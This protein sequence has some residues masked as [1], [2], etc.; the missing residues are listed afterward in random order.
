MIVGKELPKDAETRL[1]LDLEN[2]QMFN[3]EPAPKPGAISVFCVQQGD[4]NHLPGMPNAPGVPEILTTQSMYIHGFDRKGEL[5]RT[6]ADQKILLIE[7]KPTGQKNVIAADETAKFQTSDIC[8]SAGELP[9]QPAIAFKYGL[10]VLLILSIAGFFIW[11]QQAG[12]K[13]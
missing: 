11:L 3:N 9:S 6:G 4:P 13:E 2:G 1:D 5:L 10:I 12:P 8:F 7:L